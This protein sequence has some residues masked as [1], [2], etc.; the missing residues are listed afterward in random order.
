MTRLTSDMI[1]DPSVALKKLD[2][3]LIESSGFDALELAARAV[4]CPLNEARNRLLKVK[5]AVVPMGCGEGVISGFAEAVAA[6]LDH[7][8]MEPFVTSK[9]DVAGFGQALSGGV[10]V[11]FAADDDA[12]LALNLKNSRVADNSWATAKGFTEALIAAAVKLD[13][14]LEGEKVIVLGLG[15]VGHHAARFLMEAGAF[16]LVFDTENEK[17]MSFI[18]RNPGAQGVSDPV[19]ALRNINYIFDATPAKDIITEDMINSGS[20]VACP[21][22]PSGLTEAAQKK[23]QNGF[24]HDNLY[25]GV[26]VMAVASVCLGPVFSH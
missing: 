8:G 19:S 17:I 25:L 23:I 2:E 6:N 12:F 22:V 16:V 3:R 21:G 9:T 11:V 1:L 13:G 10:D 14:G 7:V 15:A 24:I 4:S 26:T 18:R 5:A 20:I